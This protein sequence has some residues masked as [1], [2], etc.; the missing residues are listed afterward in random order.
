VQTQCD[1]KYVASFLG[2]SGLVYLKGYDGLVCSIK[3]T[4]MFV[5]AGLPHILMRF[6]TLQIAKEVRKS[7]FYTTGFIGYFYIL[8][9]VIGFGSIVLL[10]SNPIYLD[11]L[12]GDLIGGNNMVAIYLSHA[13]G[14]D[15]FLGFIF[16]VVFAT[17]GIAL[18]ASAFM[19]GLAFAIATNANFPIL[20]LSKYWSKLATRVAVIGGSLGLASVIILVI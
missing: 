12:T 13:I 8:T 2:I 18:V 14:G 17:I 9:F 20:F 6:F 19:V 1:Y 7:L 16:A 10:A 11:L 3:I 5:A 15:L 4:L